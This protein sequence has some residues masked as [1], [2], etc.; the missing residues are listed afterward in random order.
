MSLLPTYASEPLAEQQPLFAKSAR[1]FLLAITIL[2]LA[3]RLIWIYLYEHVI[4]NER[5]EYARVAENL[6]TSVGYIGILDGRETLIPP[7]F[8]LLIAAGRTIIDNSEIAA[9]I[10]SCIS[11][12]AVIWPAY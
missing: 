4:V 2:A 8:P 9:R 11:G 1:R 3:I 10:V 6:L 12:I 7:L 5:V